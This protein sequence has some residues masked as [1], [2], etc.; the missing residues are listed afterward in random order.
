MRLQSC[1]LSQQLVL[2]VPIG[3][4]ERH[5]TPVT[6]SLMHRS[7]EIG[8]CLAGARRSFHHCIAIV[9]QGIHH[10]VLHLQLASTGSVASALQVGGQKTL[11][12]G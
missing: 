3:G 2:Q 8:Q 9:G 1:D 7:G 10:Q 6:Q 5:P 4:R 12:G 11:R